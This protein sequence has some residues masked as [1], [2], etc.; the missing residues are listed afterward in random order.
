[1][2]DSPVSFKSDAGRSA[3]P[4]SVSDLESPSGR[5]WRLYG[6]TRDGP[7]GAAGAARRRRRSRRV[8]EWVPA[9]GGLGGGGAGP[10]VGRPVRKDPDGVARCLRND[11]L[12]PRP[13]RPA[14][15]H[16]HGVTEARRF[17]LSAQ[18]R[19]GPGPFRGAPARDAFCT[20]ADGAACVAPGASLAR[21][22]ARGVEPRRT[23]GPARTLVGGSVPAAAPGIGRGWRAQFCAPGGGPAGV[24]GAVAASQ[25][26]G[27]ALGSGPAARALCVRQGPRGSGAQARARPAGVSSAPAEP[28]PGRDR[29]GPGASAAAMTAA[30][31]TRAGVRPGRRAARGVRRGRVGTEGAAPSARRQPGAGRAPR[32][33]LARAP[34]PRARRRSLDPRA[35]TPAGPADAG[36]PLDPGP[37]VA[38]GG[39]ARG[40]ETPAPTLGSRPGPGPTLDA[41]AGPRRNRPLDVSSTVQRCL[42]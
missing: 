12:E 25:R 33:P 40:G 8:G 39:R 11:A 13:S 4:A 36:P 3:S 30:A 32:A 29:P 15:V 21:A 34:A 27:M 19:R 35:D 1:M 22:E 28:V 7:E 23:H 18:S 24:G 31:M 5:G 37:G 16:R 2:V 14:A 38:A 6:S 42:T 20:A 9:G 26:R 17:T 41:T 10:G